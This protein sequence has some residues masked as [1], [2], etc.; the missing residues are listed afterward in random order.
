MKIDKAYISSIISLVFLVFYLIG[1]Y[2]GYYS[3]TK[4]ATAFFYLMGL[5]WFS[6]INW[7]L[8]LFHLIIACIF[9]FKFHKP[10]KALVISGI[11]ILFLQ[12]LMFIF[13][14]YGIYLSA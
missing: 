10:C 3:N 2:L 8:G 9:K 6:Y 5:G 4:H 12:G 14:Y 13:G 7:G 11:F 1:Y